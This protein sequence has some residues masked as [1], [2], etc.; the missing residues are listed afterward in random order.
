MPRR[1]GARLFA[2]HELRAL[3]QRAGLGQAAMISFI[4]LM[5]AGLMAMV[6]SDMRG[7]GAAMLQ[8]VT[9]GAGW[10]LGPTII[11]AV[12]GLLGG[13]AYLGVALALCVGLGL[14]VAILFYSFALKPLREGPR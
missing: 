11:A 8:F 3:R 14:P 4:P 10:V 2:G 5:P 9:S 13:P 7:K 6:P 12:S 1:T